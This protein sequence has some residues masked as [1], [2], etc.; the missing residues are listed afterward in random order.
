MK[1]IFYFCVRIYHVFC[2]FQGKIR[3]DN[4]LANKCYVGYHL[5]EN[6]GAYHLFDYGDEWEHNITVKKIMPANAG[7]VKIRGK[8]PE[9]Y[10]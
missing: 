5:S 9:Q 4:C 2:G 7:E 10:S 6:C 8:I 1:I 3:V